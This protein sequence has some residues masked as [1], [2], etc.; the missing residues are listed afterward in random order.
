MSQFINASELETGPVAYPSAV[1]DAIN[2]LVKQNWDGQRSVFSEDQLV[3]A[4]QVNFPA[5]KRENYTHPVLKA[6]GHL[7]DAVRAL[8]AHGFSV[9]AV[10]SVSGLTVFTVRKLQD[11]SEQPNENGERSAEA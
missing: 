8:R 11:T 10:Q 2:N 6:R 5:G 1:V 3:S 9:S 7:G 4:I